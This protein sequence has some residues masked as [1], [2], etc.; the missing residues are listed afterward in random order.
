LI[1]GL[2]IYLPTYRC[3]PLIDFF[4]FFL[5]APH[6]TLSSFDHNVID[7]ES[8]ERNGDLPPHI[9]RLH[10]EHGKVDDFHLAIGCDGQFSIC[11]TK[12]TQPYE[13]NRG[14]LPVM[15]PTFPNVLME[16]W[17]PASFVRA[18]LGGHFPVDPDGEVYGTR[19]RDLIFLASIVA[20]G[21]KSRVPTR[22]RVRNLASVPLE[23]AR[24]FSNTDWVYW[25]AMTTLYRWN[26]TGFASPET[27]ISPVYPTSPPPLPQDLAEHLFKQYSIPTV[28]E[29]VANSDPDLVTVGRYTHVLPFSHVPTSFTP[30]LVLAGQSWC[31]MHPASPLRDALSIEDAATLALCL[32]NSC[33]L[34]P[35]TY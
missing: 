3:V 11:R 12:L 23:E 1:L 35:G 15:D 5:H 29:I 22:M 7:L 6:S 4:F 21:P 2:S 14:Y 28:S 20:T 32:L 13:H 24:K 18:A 34:N 8:S 9:I 31:P 10:F 17:A 19:S 16:G 25:Q 33:F 27:P 30:N 26:L